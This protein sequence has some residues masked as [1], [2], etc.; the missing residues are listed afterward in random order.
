MKKLK[1]FTL[2]EILLAIAILGLMGLM[3]FGSFQ[4]LVSATQRAES[5]MDDL[6]VSEYLLDQI[7]E[8]LRSAA[9]FGTSPRLYQFL[10]E[11]G[12]GT[13]PNDTI[14]WVTT[15]K[16]FLP[17]SYPTRNGLNRIELSV[18]DV[19]GETG[20]AVRAYSS[21]LDP[22][23]DEAEDVEPWIITHKVKGL[24][25]YFYDIGEEKWVEDWERD[26]QLPI[27]LS[28]TLYIQPEDPD[29]KLQSFTRR[30]DIPVGKLSRDTRRGKRQV[31]EPV[32]NP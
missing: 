14:S 21:L 15:S 22:E 7:S 18:Q 10:Y 23:S 19:D 30:V 20:L 17:A 11:E 2:L 32:R 25:F 1:G 31:E 5:A 9:Y 8:A 29:A 28:F 24:E 26:N 3:V 27:S 13:P 12:T 16:S 6:H 4:S